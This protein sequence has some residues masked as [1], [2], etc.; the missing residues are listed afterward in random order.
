L[1]AKVTGVENSL[2]RRSVRRQQMKVFERRTVTLGLSIHASTSRAPG[3]FMMTIVL[4]EYFATFFTSVS[5]SLSVS[6]VRSAPSLEY[7]LMK[8]RLVSENSAHC[9][10]AGIGSLMGLKPVGT[11]VQLLAAIY[12]TLNDAFV[13]DICI[14]ASRGDTMYGLLLEPDP[15]PV[16]A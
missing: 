9:E 1:F 15:P 4:L 12:L 8:T 3:V 7:A 2:Y 11:T 5:C 10:I 6:S 13:A 16:T 14:R